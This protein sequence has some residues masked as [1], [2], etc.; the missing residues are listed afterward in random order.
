[1]SSLRTRLR[2]L[3][4]IVGSSAPFDPLGSPDT[5][6]ELF[7]DW[8]E[9]AIERG[10]PEP[11]AATLSTVDLSGIPD[12]RVLVLKDVTEDG[13]FEIATGME[14]AKGAQLR[15]NPACALS[16]YW[17][18]L[19]RAVRIRGVA[20]RATTEESARDFAA[21]HPD[22]KAITL[23]GRQSRTYADRDEHDRLLADAHARLAVDQDLVSPDWAVWRVAP[24]TVEFWQGESTRDHTRLQY[25]R[26]ADT[27]EKRRLWS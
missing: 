6:R 26:V 12:A 24:L 10:V 22:A 13:A 15:A 7:V 23:V 20:E 1:M 25:V 5:P 27:W 8:L 19:A 4:S 16:F 9:Q 21:R 17:S 11:Q 3:P 2:A 18:S 14:S